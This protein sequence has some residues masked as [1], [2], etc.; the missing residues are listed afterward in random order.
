MPKIQLLDEI[1]GKDAILLQSCFPKG[2]IGLNSMN[3]M[4][5]INIECSLYYTF[6]INYF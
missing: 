2:V 3:D 4:L 1:S 5:F 6:F